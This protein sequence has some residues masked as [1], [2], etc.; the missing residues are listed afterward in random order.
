[1]QELHGS[2]STV[3]LV[4][5]AINNC[6]LCGANGDHWA[7]LVSIRIDVGDSFDHFLFDSSPSPKLST[8]AET[9]AV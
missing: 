3:K 2:V 8:I 6:D 9:V 4:L 1:M 5:S 7:L